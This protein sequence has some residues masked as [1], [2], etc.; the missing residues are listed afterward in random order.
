[1]ICDCICYLQEGVMSSA[2][3][4][5]FDSDI[6]QVDKS[7]YVSTTQNV[8]T[9]FSSNASQIRKLENLSA[10]I[11]FEDETIKAKINTLMTQL[12][13]SEK[14]I[15]AL[16]NEPFATLPLSIAARSDN[17]ILSSRAIKCLQ[18]IIARY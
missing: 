2:S 3:L 8:D 12:A 5:K 13:E 4:R 15:F 11:L 16:S 7:N 17:S 18:Q 9:F 10:A 1:M 6:E 14:S